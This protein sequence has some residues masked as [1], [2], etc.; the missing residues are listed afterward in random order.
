[1]FQR[2]LGMRVVLMDE[3]VPS[4][5]RHSGVQLDQGAQWVVKVFASRGGGGWRIGHESV[6]LVVVR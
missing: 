1:M 4:W 2:D 6:V 5:I 3:S